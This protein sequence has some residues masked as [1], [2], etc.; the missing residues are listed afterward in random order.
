MLDG[1]EEGSELGSLDKTAVGIELGLLLG[2]DVSLLMKARRLIEFWPAS[3][4]AFD[5]PVAVIISVTCADARL[6]LLPR[7]IAAIPAT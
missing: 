2:S 5:V 1:A 3:L 4:T 7:R 6:E